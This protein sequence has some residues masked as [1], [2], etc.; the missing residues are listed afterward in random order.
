MPSMATVFVP[1]YCAFYLHEK[2]VNSAASGLYDGKRF[3]THERISCPGSVACFVILN[4]LLWGKS[5]QWGI[6]ERTWDSSENQ[7]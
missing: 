7:I 3:W 5:I 6:S 4:D 2:V 1:N